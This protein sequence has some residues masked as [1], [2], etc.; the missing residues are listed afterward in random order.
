M[1]DSGAAGPLEKSDSVLARGNAL[2]SSGPVLQGDIT[3]PCLPHGAQSLGHKDK[4]TTCTPRV[5]WGARP[6]LGL[7]EA[8]SK[9]SCQDGP[10]TA[11]APWAQTLCGA[12]SWEATSC[13][14]DFPKSTAGPAQVVRAKGSSDPCGGSR[15]DG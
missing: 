4:T 8:T 10:A 11:A 12:S 15:H 9:G 6:E 7:G 2:V 5:L 3:E 13:V 14:R 1:A